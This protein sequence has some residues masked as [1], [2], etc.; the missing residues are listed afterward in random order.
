MKAAVLYGPKDLRIERIPLPDKP[1]RGM[2]LVRVTATGICG[3]DLNTF[4]EFSAGKSIIMGHEFTGVVEAVGPEALDGYFHLLHQGVRVAVDPAQ[5]CGQCER[6][7]QGDQNLCENLHFIG[8][9]PDNGS[10][11]QYIIVQAHSCFPLP[12][13]IDDSQGVML[14]PLGVA[15]HATDLARICVANSIAILGAGPIG[16]CILQL[17]KLSGAWPIFVTDKFAWRLDIAKRFG[18]TTINCDQQDPV[19]EVL[20]M[21]NG[22]GVDIAMEVAWADKS[23]QQAIDMARL[24][25]R[26]V[27]V[28]IPHNDQMVM[29]ASSCRRKGLTMRMCR[30]MKHTYPRAIRLVQSG[31][32][33]LSRLV[34]HHFPFDRVTE[35]YALNTSYSDNVLKVIIDIDKMK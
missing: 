3:T 31:Q 10:L 1:A 6:C 30:R 4:Q 34:S 12:D 17:A 8:L 7:E 21:T 5:S 9:Y 27:L 32:V 14:E 18:A 24:G 15:I 20:K 11:C 33:N 19:E 13:S 23:I 35:A 26:L 29:K 16:L 22:R 2:V 25:G 28:G